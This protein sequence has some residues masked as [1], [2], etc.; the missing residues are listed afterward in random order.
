MLTTPTTPANWTIG[1]NVDRLRFGEIPPQLLR[2]PEPLNDGIISSIRTFTFGLLLT[3]SWLSSVLA[4]L[5]DWWLQGWIWINQSREARICFVNIEADSAPQPD[6]SSRIRNRSERH[7][8]KKKADQTPDAPLATRGMNSAWQPRDPTTGVTADNPPPTCRMPT[9]RGNTATT[10]IKRELTGAPHRDRWELTR[11]ETGTNALGLSTR[12]IIQVIIEFKTSYCKLGVD[13]FYSNLLQNTITSKVERGVQKWSPT[14]SCQRGQPANS[15]G[16]TSNQTGHTGDTPNKSLIDRQKGF[17]P[18]RGLQTRHVVNVTSPSGFLC[19]QNQTGIDSIAQASAFFLSESRT[20]SIRKPLNFATVVALKVWK[21]GDNLKI[22]RPAEQITHAAEREAC[23]QPFL[24]RRKGNLRKSW[25]T[26]I[27]FARIDKTRFELIPDNVGFLLSPVDDMGAS[28][29]QDLREAEIGMM[30]EKPVWN[31]LETLHTRRAQPSSHSSIQWSKLLEM[32][33]AEGA[34]MACAEKLLGNT[35]LHVRIWTKTLSNNAAPPRQGDAATFIRRRSIPNEWNA[36]HPDAPPTWIMDEPEELTRGKATKRET[37]AQNLQLATHGT[38][39]RKTRLPKEVWRHGQ[40]LGASNAGV[41]QRKLCHRGGARYKIQP[42]PTRRAQQTNKQ[43]PKQRTFETTHAPPNMPTY[44]SAAVPRNYGKRSVSPNKE[45]PAYRA[46]SFPPPSFDPSIPIPLPTLAPLPCDVLDRRRTGTFGPVDPRPRGSTPIERLADATHGCEYLDHNQEVHKLTDSPNANHGLADTTTNWRSQAPLPAPEPRRPAVASSAIHLL[47]P[48]PVSP[49]VDASNATL[50][51]RFLLNPADQPPTKATDSLRKLGRATN[52]D[53]VYI[54]DPRDE[55]APRID[56]PGLPLKLVDAMPPMASLATPLPATS[57]APQPVTPVITHPSSAIPQPQTATVTYPTSLSPVGEEDM[58]ISDDEAAMEDI[59]VTPPPSLPIGAAKE[60]S[61]RNDIR[62]RLHYDARKVFH[63]LPD[64]PSKTALVF[65][66]FLTPTPTTPVVST[67]NARAL[68][69]IG[70]EEKKEAARKRS[71]F[72]AN[73]NGQVLAANITRALSPLTSFP[74]F[75][76]LQSSG[77]DERCLDAAPNVDLAEDAAAS[78]DEEGEIHPAPADV[79]HASHVELVS[80][81]VLGNGKRGPLVTRECFSSSPSFQSA[82]SGDLESDGEISLPSCFEIFNP[83]DHVVEEARS[84]IQES[85]RW[86]EQGDSDVRHLMRKLSIVSDQD[87]QESGDESDEGDDEDSS[88]SPPALMSVSSDSEE[89][90]VSEP[91]VAEF[92][93]DMGTND[94]ISRNN[95][96]SGPIALPL[97]QLKQ[98]LARQTGFIHLAPPAFTIEAGAHTRIEAEIR[99]WALDLQQEAL[100]RRVEQEGFV[101]QPLQDFVQ[102]VLAHSDLLL[103]RDAMNN[104]RGLVNIEE[105]HKE[106]RDLLDHGEDNAH[107]GWVSLPPLN[108]PAAKSDGEQGFTSKEINSIAIPRDDGMLRLV[109]GRIAPRGSNGEAICKIGGYGA[110]QPLTYQ[111]GLAIQVSREL[112]FASCHALLHTCLTDYTDRGLGMIKQNAWTYDTACISRPA[113]VPF[114]FVNDGQNLQFRVVN[115]TMALNGRTTLAELGDA[116]MKLRFRNPELVSHML[117]SNVLRAM[118]TKEMVTNEEAPVIPAITSQARFSFRCPVPQTNPKPFQTERYEG[119]TR[120]MG[121]WATTPTPSVRAELAPAQGYVGIQR[122]FTPEPSYRHVASAS[123][124]S[125]PH[126]ASRSPTPEPAHPGYHF[127]DRFV[128]WT[129][130]VAKKV[131]TA[132]RT[133]TSS[134]TVPRGDPDADPQ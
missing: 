98:E 30:P 85:R 117:H 92:R 84:I 70:E 63:G 6:Q 24:K 105:L 57:L 18:R 83:P 102:V 33:Q 60:I 80:V 91:Y 111:G 29:K 110:T 81:P 108:S 95:S 15:V 9:Q 32:F 112:E 119:P 42:D 124:S 113:N 115:A 8:R 10:L 25:R 1:Q 50:G 87:S 49:V 26:R 134:H 131:P 107:L 16:H 38:T 39:P 100:V 99:A 36:R 90:E 56:T 34:G 55:D 130:P 23:Q 97:D 79:L 75:Q 45:H 7:L 64:E 82:S 93:A 126:V 127:A 116:I 132:S 121:T 28:D 77:K 59:A 13:E 109:Q 17:S 46:S 96:A 11:N 76:H 31:S 106:K 66:A 27:E 89:G 129:P 3:L 54:V 122:P 48:T 67:P 74:H 22:C 52:G 20:A 72:A 19:I 65:G 103:D 104:D 2:E 43:T 4:S 120:I 21:I 78:S 68:S 51:Y 86:Y 114:P 47:P 73:E 118:N 133:P 14:S 128:R 35:L 41:L 71:E 5:G 12:Q 125:Q 88:S 69:D 94:E 37:A 101:A 123:A 44:S 62:E 58:D 40:A 61:M 53:S